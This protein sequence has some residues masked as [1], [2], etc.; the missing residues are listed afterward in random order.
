MASLNAGPEYY[1]AE[2]RYRS[3]KTYED[4]MQALQEMLKF[5]PKHKSAHSILMDI[6]NRISALK[7]QKILE[8]KKKA[9]RKGAGDFVKSQGAA[10]V[11]LLG[12]PNA[13]K[14]AMF[15]ALTGLKFSS[16]PVP[17]ETRETTP[18]MMDFEKV[19]LQI[20]DLP[21]AMA[22]N[23]A[24]LF[25]VARNADLC[26]IV[27]DPLQG[28][29]RQLEFFKDAPSPLPVISKQT[30][31]SAGF[32]DPAAGL[33]SS[34]FVFDASSPDSILALKRLLVEKLDIIRVFTKNPHGE[35]DMQKPFVVRRG[36]S[37]LD[38]A[39]A[40]HKDMFKNFKFAKL[41]GGGKFAGQRVSGSYVL[42]DGD[43]LEL[44]MR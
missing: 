26:I 2:E 19:Q 16:T 15:N 6:R 4:R 37:V 10:Q 9:G 44:H 3:A 31:F 33:L 27:L 18:G 36:S 20:L 12:F 22:A 17:F 35:T 38:V 30:F 41:W 29:D 42:R 23:K 5:C 1:A 40:I 21:S 28:L 39:K 8:A 25:S 13:G 14:T 32:K 24:R 34:A 43:V 11:A 7:K